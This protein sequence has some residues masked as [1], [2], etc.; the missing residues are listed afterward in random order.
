M[1]DVSS[2]WMT[3]V[4]ER[5][6]T[7]PGAVT[8]RSTSINVAAAMQLS[9]IALIIQLIIWAA[10]GIGVLVIAVDGDWNSRITGN[11]GS[12]RS[13]TAVLSAW[14]AG[15]GESCMTGTLIVEM[16]ILLRP[17][18]AIDSATFEQHFVR[19]NVQ[20]FTLVE[21]HDQVAIDQG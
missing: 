2:G 10:R 4:A 3:I 7:R 15:R 17:K 5:E 21:H 14:D 8:T 12:P 6:M 19:C 9:T 11:V 18:L 20:E 13:A 1:I 16:A